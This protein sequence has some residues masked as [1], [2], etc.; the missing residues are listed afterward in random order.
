M[1][2]SDWI[3]L[4]ALLVTAVTIVSN[5]LLQWSRAGLDAELKKFEVT[6]LEKRRAF[7]DLFRVLRRLRG[8]AI[9]AQQTKDSEFWGALEEVADSVHGVMPF[10]KQ[11]D[12]DWLLRETNEIEKE[13]DNI[14]S[15]WKRPGAQ[16]I[17]TRL[18]PVLTQISG[19]RGELFTRLFS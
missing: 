12:H 10:L 6:F 5:Y 15:E 8:L 9:N 18:E 4:G 13:L 17:F 7:A 2:S 1:N 19:L 3:A 11:A 14:R 16:P